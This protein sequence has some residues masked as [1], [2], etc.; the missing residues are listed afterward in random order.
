[1]NFFDHQRAAKGTTLKLVLLFVAAVVAAML[2]QHRTPELP[3]NPATQ[4]SKPASNSA[5]PFGRQTADAQAAQD[6]PGQAQT[7]AQGRPHASWRASKAARSAAAAPVAP[8]A[9]A[10]G[11]L[12]VSSMPMG[13]TVEIEGRAGQH[14]RA[15]RASL[16]RSDVGGAHT[17]PVIPLYSDP[18]VA[19][20]DVV[21][22][23]A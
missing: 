20:S 4:S 18:P 14:E 7:E 5:A 16:P 17:G 6:A 3:D 21:A 9:P 11:Q 12:I 1:M 2:F 10:E 19:F 13:A 22:G 15:G 23:R 8:P